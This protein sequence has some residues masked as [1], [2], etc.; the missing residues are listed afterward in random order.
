MRR[1]I[2]YDPDC[3]RCPRLARFLAATRQQHTGYW[4]RPVPSF[5]AA[6]PRLVIVGLAPGM[7]GAN[8]TGRPFTGD[9]AGILLYGTL[10]ALGLASAPQSSSASDALELID[11]RIVN[12]VKCVPPANKPL[13]E[14]IR[15][16]NAFLRE[17]LAALPGARVY[18]ALGRIA[19][20][21]VL[22]ARGLK[23]SDY[24]F[25]HGREHRL[26]EARW[27]IDSYHC[28]RYNTQTRRL[29][30]PMFRAVVARARERAGLGRLDRD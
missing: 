14:E 17:E 7:H 28:S 30:A 18:L 20:E 2:A 25:A 1:S 8:R 23:R 5:G 19:H 24:G 6:Q 27:L 29:T 15:R 16:C 13:P 22:L 11:T 10:H 21:A 3:T 9:F 4:A 12:A 26:D